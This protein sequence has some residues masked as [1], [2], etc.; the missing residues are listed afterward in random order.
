M[1][2]RRKVSRYHLLHPL[3]G[4]IE[5]GEVRHRGEVVELSTAGFRFRLRNSSKE[6]FIAQKSSHDF[7]EIVY[8]DEMIGGFGEIRYVRAQGDDVLIG[9][10][11]D[12]V[13]A[14]D[15]IE[16]SFSIIADLIAQ[17]SAGCVNVADG[18]VELAGHI[19]SVLAEDIQ[20]SLDPKFPRVSLRECTSM[21]TS[22][23]AMLVALEDAKVLIYEASAEMRALLQRYRQQGPGSILPPAGSNSVS[24]G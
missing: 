6:A 24:A 12:D 15:N 1:L 11:W 9:F 18:M 17:H 20:Q 2:N 5:H 14:D 22:G 13:H 4:F 21:D 23:L 8:K 10:K 7:G 3:T 19:S 16:R